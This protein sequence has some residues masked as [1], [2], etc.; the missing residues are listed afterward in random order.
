MTEW[1]FHTPQYD[2]QAP[3]DCKEGLEV[4]CGVNNTWRLKCAANVLWAEGLLYRYRPTQNAK[5]EDLLAQCLALPQA[6]RDAL[7]EAL[8]K[9][10]R[11]W[12]DD[13]WDKAD[14][15]F[16]NGGKTAATAVIRSMCRPKEEN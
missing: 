12:A 8:Q 16:G 5:Q 9:P 13:V 4:E 1:K 7:V 3:H 15:A 14:T 11:D 10:V 6:D 2:G